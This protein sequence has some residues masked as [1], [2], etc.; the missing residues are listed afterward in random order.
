M[1]GGVGPSVLDRARSESA[2]SPPVAD[3]PNLPERLLVASPGMAYN[4]R[5]RPKG[6][7]PYS[8]YAIEQ[9][10]RTNYYGQTSNPR[11]RAGQHRKDGKRGKLRVIARHP[12]RKAA[13]R[14]ER[15]LLAR[16]RRMNGGRNPRYNKTWD[17]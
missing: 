10:R 7:G 14:H 6:K 9:G 15:N 8:T 3:N 4:R 17:G 13:K 2:R 16:Y 12:T 11:K 5:R 1:Y